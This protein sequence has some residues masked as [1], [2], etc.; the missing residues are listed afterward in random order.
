MVVVNAFVPQMRVNN[1]MILWFHFI[2][3]VS[4]CQ[5]LLKEAHY[6]VDTVDTIKNSKNE[7]RSSSSGAKKSKNEANLFSSWFLGFRE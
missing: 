7:G 4:S 6:T 5:I 3:D 2:D 1:V